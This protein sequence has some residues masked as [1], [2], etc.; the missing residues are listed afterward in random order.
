MS[1]DRP[2]ERLRSVVARL[3][4]PDGCPW[5]REQTHSSLRTALVEETYEVLAAI[6]ADDDEN[7]CEELG[8]LLLHVVMHAQMASERGVATRTF[9]ATTAWRTARR[10]SCAGT[11]SSARKKPAPAMRPRHQSRRGWTACRLPCR[12]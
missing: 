6:E 8:D 5:A 11:R 7:F 1:D 2:L 10:C 3:R 4:A 12:R 9:S